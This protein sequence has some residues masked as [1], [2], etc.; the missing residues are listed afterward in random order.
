MPETAARYGLS[1][2]HDPEAAIDAAARYLR[3]LLRRF[4][5]RLD[6]ALAA[7]NAGEGAVE[8]FM[9]GKPLLLRNGK[10]VNPHGLV[11]GG[12]PPYVETTKYVRSA[13]MLLRSRS[14]ND[15]GRR[16]RFR[17][18]SLKD[19]TIDTLSHGDTISDKTE[20]SRPSSY[21]EVQ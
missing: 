1:N 16:L 20:R 5:G 18:S 13:L 4:S 10:I 2:P 3:D 6:L 17:L 11:T 19:F 9:T 21:I 12:I 14:V 15:D 8:S 7:Y